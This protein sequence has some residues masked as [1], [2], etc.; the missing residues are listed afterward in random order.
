MIKKLMLPRTVLSAPFKKYQLTN[1]DGNNQG[2]GF[3]GNCERSQTMD[4]EQPELL[5]K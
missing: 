2:L 3:E 5:G 4:N 1:S